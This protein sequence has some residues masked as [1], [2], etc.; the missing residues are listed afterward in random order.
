MSQGEIYLLR[1]GETEWSRS[2]QHTGRTD[3]PLTSAGRQRAAQIAPMIDR[4]NFGL[5]LCSPLARARDTA[6]LAGLHPDAYDDDLLEWNYGAYEGRTTAEIRVEKDDPDWVIW[7]DPNPGGETPADVA[8]RSARVLALVEPVTTQG[9]NVMLVAH[10]HLLRILTATYLGLP[11]TAGRLF[12]LDP[13]GIG[14]LGHE[15]VQPVIRGWNIN[16][17]GFAD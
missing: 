9:R 7:D 4:V 14:V 6:E 12:S 13:G 15:R 1:H 5:V 2:G 3:I 10:G 17:D 8:A 16:P 11:G